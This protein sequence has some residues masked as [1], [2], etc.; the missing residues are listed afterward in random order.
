MAYYSGS[1]VNRLGFQNRIGRAAWRVVESTVFRWSPSALF[2]WRVALLRIFGA[3]IAWSARPY[4][5]VRV[6]APWNL[7]MGPRACLADGV[8]CYCVAPIMLEA[9]ATV[10]QR[11]FLCTASHDVHHPERPL[12]S[13]PITIESGGWVF[14]EAFVGMGVTVGRGAV[15]AARA[16]VVR[17]VAPGVIVG[18]NPAKT[19]GHRENRG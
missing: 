8:D 10:S 9:D 11:A 16:V 14:A 1:Y 4:P 12:I 6:W 17:D 13:G 18:G 2:V 7:S 15:V 3:R 5:T 19:I